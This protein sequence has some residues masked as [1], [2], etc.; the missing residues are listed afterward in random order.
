MA[1][2]NGYNWGAALVLCLFL[3][4]CAMMVILLGLEVFYAPDGGIFR[5]R[6]M[7][8]RNFIVAII[9]VAAHGM[10]FFPTNGYYTYQATTV[11]GRDFLQSSLRGL[12]L[13]VTAAVAGV[14]F[15]LVASWRKCVRL[16]VIVGSLTF[17]V[18][19]ILMAT[20]DTGT[21]IKVLWGYPV[22]GGIGV[23]LVVPGTV[24][25]AQI[26]LPS[27]MIAISTATILAAKGFGTGI[28][29]AIYNTIL[30]KTVNGNLP[31][32]LAAAVA[33]LGFPPEMMGILIQA[34]SSGNPQI[35]ASV[36]GGDMKMVGA[37]FGAFTDVY[38]LGFRRVWIAGCC[39]SAT[40][41]VGTFLSSPGQILEQPS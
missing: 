2:Q 5:I 35:V 22:L 36:L 13:Y 15:G 31:G 24:T 4:G 38:S 18:W 11:Y 14:V 25:V 37:A 40:G 27:S 10:A 8:D 1:S 17:L 6:T 19:N 28:S 21:S 26:S 30:T 23:G 32:K 33:P 9:C 20:I 29:S 7:L 39:F 41:L 12:M 34:L 16:L 3:L